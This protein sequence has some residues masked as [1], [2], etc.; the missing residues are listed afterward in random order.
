MYLIIFNGFSK[1]LNNLFKNQAFFKKG[2]QIN[3]IK[4]TSPSVL[5]NAKIT[6]IIKLILF[7]FLLLLLYI[8]IC[9][10]SELGY[11]CMCMACI[12]WVIAA[13]L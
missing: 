10:L 13:V 6:C 7:V 5:F 2:K 9:N 3:Y 12:H 1:H 8:E 4:L 11:L